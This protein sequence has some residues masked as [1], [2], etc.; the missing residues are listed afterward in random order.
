MAKR[1]KD[2]S[3]PTITQYLYEIM[4]W[5]GCMKIQINYQGREF[6][7]EVSKVLHNMFGTDQCMTSVHHLQSNGLCEQQNRTVKDS[8]LKVLHGNLCDWPN[9]IE[10]VLFI[11]L[12][13]SKCT[14]TKFSLFHLLYYREP[15]LPIN[16]KYNLVDIYGNES[17]H[18]LDKE[19]FV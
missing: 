16:A 1:I 6:V 3:A 4:F 10:G 8:L 15:T 19:T 14:S 17:E 13:V 11:L 9:I 5:Y 12:R 18:P 2:K 7:N